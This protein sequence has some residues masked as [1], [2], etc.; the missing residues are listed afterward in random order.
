MPCDVQLTGPP[1]DL[2]AAATDCTAGWLVRIVTERASS[3]G[4]D[5]DIAAVSDMA[6]EV[7]DGV[8]ADLGAFLST[9]VDQQRTNPLT[10]FRQ[11]VGTPTAVLA[12]LGAPM[13]H[14]DP[15]VVERF[16]EDVYGLSPAV[17]ADIDPAMHEPGLMWGAWKA[18]TVLQ[19]RRGD[20]PR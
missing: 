20:E 4:I 8:L 9:D 13:I 16:P 17:W 6:S 1:A 18:M 15:F 11:A 7:A 12:A 5:V 2:L 14:R 3:A 10:I 19:R